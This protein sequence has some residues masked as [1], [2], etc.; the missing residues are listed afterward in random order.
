M[1]KPVSG[2]AGI[3][4]NE[5]ELLKA[6]QAIRAA[7]F[8]KFDAI[9]PFP[10]HGMD[11]AIGLKRSKLPIVS[12]IAGL[13]GFLTALGFQSYVFV[14]DWPLNIGGKPH[15]PLPAFV[16]VLFELTVLFSALVT[17]GTLIAWC[18]LPRF[19]PPVIDM[20]LTDD[21]FAIFIPED[22][23]N[24]DVQKIDSLFQKLGA[25]EIRKVREF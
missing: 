9:T 11:D 1:A 5:H 19:N 18:G 4:K 21:K 17:A 24:F 12:F 16:P 3:W 10:I 2:L 7:G 13:I 8:E 14:W 6:A 22:D 15:F 23:R 20:R 25:D